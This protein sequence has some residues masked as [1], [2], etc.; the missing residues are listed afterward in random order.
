MALEPLRLFGEPG[1]EF[2]QL[3]VQLYVSVELGFLV[4]PGAEAGHLASE[5]LVLGQGGAA[6]LGGGGVRCGRKTAGRCPLRTIPTRVGRTSSRA[7]RNSLAAD[8]PHAG[9]ENRVLYVVPSCPFGPSPRGWG[10]R[11]YTGADFDLPR[12]IP[13]RVGRTAFSRFLMHLPPDHPHAG[14]ENANNE[15]G[16]V[17]S[18]GPSPR[19]WGER[20]SSMMSRSGCRTIPTR[21][22]RTR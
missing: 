15:L 2:F 7:V 5:A 1:F 4:C 18:P 8:H 12:T 6:A 13:T 20:E 21:V 16:E 10:E 3:E 11:E 14:G 9:G 19:G 17:T 22:G